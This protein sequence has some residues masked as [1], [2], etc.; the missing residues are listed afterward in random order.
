MEKLQGITYWENQMLLRWHTLVYYGFDAVMM[1]Q[2]MDDAEIH[3]AKSKRDSDAQPRPNLSTMNVL[4]G[5]KVLLLILLL[6]K[7]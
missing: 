6:R 7:V 5:K 1:Q 4:T 2:S 3:Y